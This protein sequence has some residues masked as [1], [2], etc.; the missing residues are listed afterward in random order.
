MR[1]NQWEA[2]FV[3]RLNR[4]VALVDR[5]NGEHLEVHVP[6]SGRME[7]LLVPGAE[8]MV[9][10]FAIDRGQKTVGRLAKVLHAD[11][12]WVSI[13]SH[14]PNRL[15]EKAIRDGRL[16]E[17]TGW[18]DLR[19]EAVYGHSRLDFSLTLNGRRGLIEVKS[20][21]LV[22][23]GIA[24]FPDAPTVRGARH[25]RELAMAAIKGYLA[26]LVFVIQRDDAYVFSPHKVRD[27]D[28][29]EAVQEATVAG[30][31]VLAYDCQV[32]PVDVKLRRLVP[33]KL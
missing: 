7:E 25:V 15:M 19:P 4:F 14:L 1:T 30:V 16:A 26:F 10:P 12:V 3:N 8:V 33:I 11:G 18:E 9:E 5:G 24:L 13:D 2:R 17:F 32:S 22:E 23:D 6:S 27:P 28:F 20:V 31:T 29:A 21:T